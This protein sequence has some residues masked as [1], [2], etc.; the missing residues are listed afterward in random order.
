MDQVAYERLAS[1]RGE[2]FLLFAAVTAEGRVG[3]VTLARLSNA[4]VLSLK[5]IN[6]DDG[7]MCP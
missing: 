7:L 2:N 6:E 4:S 1:R 5:P 3:F